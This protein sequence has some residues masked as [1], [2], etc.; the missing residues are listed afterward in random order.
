MAKQ[1]KERVQIGGQNDGKPIYKWATGYTQQEL[2]FNAA[3][4]LQEYGLMKGQQTKEAPTS[5]YF[6]TYVDQWWALYKEPK[7]RHTTK[8]SYLNLIKNHIT[9]FFKDMRLSE[10]TTS[11]IQA[12]LNANSEKAHSTVRQMRVILHQIFDLAVEDG[13]M[14]TNPTNSK[15]LYIAARKEQKRRALEDAEI[16]AIIKGIP[17]LK[18]EDGALLAL[19]LFTGM[20]RGEVL[21][22]RWEDINWKKRLISVQRSVTYHNNHPVLG[23]TKSDAGIRLIP[24]EDQLADILKPLRQLNGFII[25][26]QEPITET[27]FKR[28][29]QRISKKIDL[30][31]ATPHIFR[32]TYITLAA[33]SGLD[34]KTLQSIAGHS[35]IKM[36]LEKYAH[37]R[38]KKVMEAGEIIGNVFRSM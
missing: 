6:K 8:G 21:A 23:E 14:K 27:T 35:D 13:H 32:H 10:I 20:R 30:F 22:L 36:T 9:P 7:L 1:L 19:L 16:N 5:P 26:G 2:L 34:V 38:E 11:T 3:L 12:F 31:G 4:I 25:G 33:S 15:R 24:L 29:W 17:C 18:S 28:M 37:A